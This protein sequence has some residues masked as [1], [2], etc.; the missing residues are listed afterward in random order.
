MWKPVIFPVITCETLKN[1]ANVILIVNEDSR[2]A[3][4]AIW[5]KIFSGQE[6]AR[7]NEGRYFYPLALLFLRT[8]SSS[9]LKTLLPCN[10]STSNKRNESGVLVCLSYCRFL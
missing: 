9:F 3:G 1:A 10:T 4:P 7:K 5:D 2:N 8:P 6:G